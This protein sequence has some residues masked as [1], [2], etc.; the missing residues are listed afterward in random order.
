MKDRKP[1]ELK[2]TLIIYNIVQVVASVV[3]VFEVSQLIGFYSGV[4]LG[5]ISR[6]LSL[7]LRF[8]HNGVRSRSASPR[9]C[10][11]PMA[12]MGFRSLLYQSV[13]K[14]HCYRD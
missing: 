7:L 13:L 8:Q 9:C 6:F 3:L 14:R 12:T 11:E 10:G 1:F 4:S 5:R 2:K